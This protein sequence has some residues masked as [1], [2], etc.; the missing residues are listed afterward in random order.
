MFDIVGFK[1][2]FELFRSEVE[3]ISAVI[4]SELGDSSFNWKA[5]SRWVIKDDSVWF[6]TTEISALHGAESELAYTIPIYL[7][8]LPDEQIRVLVR[9]GSI[10]K[11]DKVASEFIDGVSVGTSDI[12]ALRPLKVVFAGSS[13]VHSV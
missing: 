6:Y 4:D 8:N 10:L 1:K 3:R 7:F 12:L 13:P 5:V 11:K 9:A 2:N